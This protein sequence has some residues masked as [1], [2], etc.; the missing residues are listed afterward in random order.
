MIISPEI[1]KYINDQWFT[2]VFNKWQI[3]R[4]KPGFANTNSNIESF[5]ATIKRDFTNR[6]RWTIK[7]ALEKIS[8]IITHSS[9]KK[10]FETVPAYN[11]GFSS[12][13]NRLDKSHF[14]LNRNRV[15]YVGANGNKYLISIEKKCCS[16]KHFLN[17][18]ICPHV[19]A[20]S[21]INQLNWFGDEYNKS[22]KVDFVNK[23]KRGPKGGRYKKAEKALVKK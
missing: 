13:S 19:I 15:F 17:Y 10:Y 5:N 20:Y 8:N 16:C 23:N 9:N 11:K 14:K 2:G 1:F 12:Y 4:N 21:N 22:E 6:K 3:F 7:L 18:A